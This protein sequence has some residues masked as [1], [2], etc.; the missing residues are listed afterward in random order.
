MSE[1]P[2]VEMDEQE[3]TEWLQEQFEYEY[4]DECGGDAEDHDCVPCPLGNPF[5]R[6]KRENSALLVSARLLSCIL[7]FGN[8]R[9]GFRVR[10]GQES[11]SIPAALGKTLE[12]AIDRAKWG[13]EYEQER[14]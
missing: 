3:R 2:W 10:V 5:A 1:K 13:L 8:N 14:S 11:R 7:L 4:C 9:E 6:C 12:V